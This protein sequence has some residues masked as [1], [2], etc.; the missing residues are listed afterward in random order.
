MRE[1]REPWKIVRYGGRER[2]NQNRN[3]SVA[4]E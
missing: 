3:L 1:I 4:T 2:E